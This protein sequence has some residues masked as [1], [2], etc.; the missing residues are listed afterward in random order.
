M[1]GDEIAAWLPRDA[2]GNIE[3]RPRRLWGLSSTFQRLACTILKSVPCALAF[4]DPRS[5]KGNLA[6]NGGERID[7][8][9]RLPKSVVMIRCAHE[10]RAAIL[11]DANAGL[12]SLD[13]AA[14]DALPY[15]YALDYWHIT[16]QAH[17]TVPSGVSAALET[18]GPGTPTPRIAMRRRAAADR[19]KIR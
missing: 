12:R 13:P 7:T 14:A 2:D 18:S 15:R 8:A 16:S 10:L 1:P 3:R 19:R 9:L 5:R 17:A 6:N 4:V 11:A